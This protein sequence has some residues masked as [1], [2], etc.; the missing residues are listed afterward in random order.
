[1][2]RI[3]IILS[4]C[5][6]KGPVLGQEVINLLVIKLYLYLLLETF[7]TQFVSDLR[8]VSGFLRVLRFPSPI[9]LT[10]TI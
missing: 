2:Y 7:F 9:K 4:T 6:V 3:K 10:A 8:Q 1:M 5:K